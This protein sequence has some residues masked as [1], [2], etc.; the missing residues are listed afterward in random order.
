MAPR[1]PECVTA[2]CMRLIASLSHTV[3]TV[4]HTDTCAHTHNTRTHGRTHTVTHTPHTV[5]LSLTLSVSRCHCDG[6]CHSTGHWLELPL[7][8][9]VCQP[10]GRVSVTVTVTVG[11]CI[12]DHWRHCQC[13]QPWF[14]HHKLK[15][16]MILNEST[17]DIAIKSLPV[18]QLVEV[19][20]RDLPARN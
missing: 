18:V 19:Q 4:T 17:S 10:G 1:V 15:F 20:H 11:Q 13:H 9:W 7:T 8:V 12:T 5:W 16:T 2:S 14:R 6:L 3:F